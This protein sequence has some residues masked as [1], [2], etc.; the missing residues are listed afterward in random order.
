M[1]TPE[2][3]GSIGVMNSAHM[4]R[5]GMIASLRRAVS[6]LWTAAAVLR[7]PRVPGSSLERGGRPSPRRVRE[8]LTQGGVRSF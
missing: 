3:F 6:E 7:L 1:N 8:V 4:H 5:R 2:W